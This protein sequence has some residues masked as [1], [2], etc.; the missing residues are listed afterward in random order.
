MNPH[1]PG[2]FVEDR[3]QHDGLEGWSRGGVG[4]PTEADHRPETITTHIPNP[5]TAAG[6]AAGHFERPSHIF[7][8]NCNLFHHR[9]FD[10]R[11]RVPS[12]ARPRKSGAPSKSRYWN[13]PTRLTRRRCFLGIERPASSSASISLEQT[14]SAMAIAPAV[15]DFGSIRRYPETHSF[16]RP[17][18]AS[19]G[20]F[21]M[22]IPD[23]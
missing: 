22:P 7:L 20:A 3:G 19:L 5:P 6:S 4:R 14:L 9:S 11:L 8:R 21:L 23:S 15:T 12:T 17:G 10:A 13:A 2:P 16:A 1:R 18:R